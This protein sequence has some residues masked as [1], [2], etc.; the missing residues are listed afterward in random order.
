MAQRSF[1]RRCLFA[2]AFQANMEDRSYPDAEDLV[3]YRI[4]VPIRQSVFYIL[5]SCELPNHC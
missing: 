5:L 4:S 3:T 1:L 2:R